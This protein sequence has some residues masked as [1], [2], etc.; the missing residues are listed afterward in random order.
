MANDQLLSVSLTLPVPRAQV[1]AFFSD[2]ANLGRI[3]PPELHFRIRTPGTIEMRTGALIEYSIGL[4]GI[5][6]RWKSEI[7]RWS[8][9]V[10][11]EDTQLRGPYAKWVH[12]HRF[13]ETT[14]G[15]VIEDVVRYALP[16]GTVGLI[17]LP[18]VRRQLDRIFRF[19]TDAVRRLLVER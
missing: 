8:P 17:A 6:M 2:A 4:W 11:F 10:E 5:P 9:P 3:T 16:F 19:R 18:L 15:T 14:D 1:F 12:T 13:T 7:T